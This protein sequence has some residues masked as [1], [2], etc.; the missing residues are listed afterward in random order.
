MCL[1][2][3]WMLWM[4]MFVI[5][6]HNLLTSDIDLCFFMCERIARSEESLP[7]TVLLQITVN[8]HYIVVLVF[9]SLYPYSVWNGQSLLPTTRCILIVERSLHL[10]SPLHNYNWTFWNDFWYIW[11]NMYH[12]FLPMY[13]FLQYI[14]RS[15][16]LPCSDVHFF[17]LGLVAIRYTLYV[18]H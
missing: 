2:W 11:F 16:T 17:R 8:L 10:T 12:Y 6:K 14:A 9:V 18:M 13:N 5:S 1:F 3:I 7:S 4:W 15:E